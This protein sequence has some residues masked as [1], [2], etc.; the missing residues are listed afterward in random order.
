MNKFYVFSSFIVF[1][2]IT[3]VFTSCS[4]HTAESDSAT[5]ATENESTVI[6]VSPPPAELN[7]DTA[8][9]IID[10]AMLG[11]NP[12]FHELV[13]IATKKMNSELDFHN[14]KIC[15]ADVSSITYDCVAE[16][17]NLV[18]KYEKLIIENYDKLPEQI[19][20]EK[21][22]ANYKDDLKDYFN[23]TKS[24]IE[25]K[26][27]VTYGCDVLLYNPGHNE[28]VE[29]NLFKAY[30]MELYEINDSMLWAKSEYENFGIK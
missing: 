15:S 1:C 10:R 29:Y 13:D 6:T 30:A 27:K 18:D 8:K 5:R 25:L 2:A 16:L 23:M 7:D 28:D 9:E 24:Q 22:P 19:K 20:N 3:T 4:K 26:F 21:L 17:R 11:I 14:N 12:D